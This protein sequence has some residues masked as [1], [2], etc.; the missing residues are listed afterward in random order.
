MGKKRTLAQRRFIDAYVK[1]EGNATAAY[2]SLHPDCKK[3]SAADLGYRML[4]KVDITIK[5]I[6]DK[7][8]VTDTYLSQKLNEGLEAKKVVSIIPIIPKKDQPNDPCL[9]EATS[10][11][12]E[13]VDV[14]DFAVRQRYLDMAFKL[15][16]K[17]PVERHKIDLPEDI[18]IKVKITE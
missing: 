8:G 18:T 13:F 17:Y 14:D 9:Q 12:L 1:F 2:L 3:T 4:R 11:S 16:D 7:I 15:K 10:K 5:E 6:L